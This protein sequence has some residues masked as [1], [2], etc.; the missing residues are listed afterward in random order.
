MVKGEEEA[1]TVGKTKKEMKKNTENC[2]RIYDETQTE[3]RRLNNQIRWETRNAAKLKEKEIAK[4]V[5]ENPKI[6]WKYVASKSRTSD[7]YIDERK[8]TKTTTDKEK[9][10]VL[11]EKNA[12]LQCSSSPNQ[13]KEF[14]KCQKE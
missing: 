12:S 7:L 10:Q 11:S 8:E 14:L 3:Y 6:F 4:N 5:K 2:N 9:A 13:R 1:K